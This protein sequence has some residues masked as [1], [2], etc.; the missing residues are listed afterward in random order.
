MQNNNTLT[1][2]IIDL[3]GKTLLKGILENDVDKIEVLSLSGGM[4]ILELDNKM[5]LRFVKELDNCQQV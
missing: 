5:S 1:W 2:R 4:Y 3:R